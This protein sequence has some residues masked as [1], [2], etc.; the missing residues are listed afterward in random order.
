MFDLLNIWI[1]VRRSIYE[2]QCGP[3]PTRDVLI[4]YVAFLYYIV[5]DLPAGLVDN[6]HF[7]LVEHAVMYRY[8][9]SGLENVLLLVRYFEWYPG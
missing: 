9:Q 4:Q 3:R 6:K 8:F 1:R 2:K 5:Q 7:P